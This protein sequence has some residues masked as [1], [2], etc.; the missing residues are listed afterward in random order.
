METN[1]NQAD[2]EV[3][4]TEK[5]PFWGIKNTSYLVDAAVF[6]VLGTVFIL[7]CYERRPDFLVITAMVYYIMVI[8]YRSMYYQARE[9][10][11]E[12]LDTYTSAL[13]RWQPIIDKLVDRNKEL[14][15]ENAKLKETIKVYEDK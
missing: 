2:I 10:L 14:E 4:Y 7:T 6:L 9:M 8:M 5:K 11:L 15:E 1:D 3:D 13:K 12:T